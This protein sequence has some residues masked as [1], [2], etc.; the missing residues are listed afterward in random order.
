[1]PKNYAELIEK[2]NLRTNPDS[3][4]SVKMFSESI[5]KSKLFE[6]LTNR[7]VEVTE[8]IRKAMRGVNPTYTQNSKIAAA[9]VKAHLIKSHGTNVK[10]EYQGSVMTNTHI[11]KDND[12]DIVQLTSKSSEFNHSG[13]KNAIA[14]P[15]SFT[16]KEIENLKKHERDFQKYNGNKMQDLLDVREKSEKVLSSQYKEVE[17]KNKSICVKVS[18]PKRNVDVVTA[19]FYKGVDYMRSNGNHRKGVQIY[20]KDANKLLDLDYPF[21]SIKRINE[22]NIL[23]TGRLKNMIR[24]IKNVKFDSDLIDN[25]SCVIKSFHINAICYNISLKNYEF[26]HFLDLVS[27]VNY[28][29]LKI[30]SDEN[31]RNSLRSVDG[32]ELIFEK[33]TLQKLKEIKFLQQEIDSILADL[34]NQNLLLG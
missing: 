24:F 23:S 27:V 19:I 4:K 14:N 17:I 21:W 2:I 1:M 31:Y 30:L 7:D 28:E 18:S 33:N 3:Y 13:L 20:D 8:Y 34:S 26:H 15:V 25:P 5:S 10:F 9:Q 6:S 12:I 11:L 16:S 29:F 32:T 22:K